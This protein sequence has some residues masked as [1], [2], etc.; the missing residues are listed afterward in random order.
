MRLG[1]SWPWERVRRPGV[2]RGKEGQS[3]IYEG[4]TRAIGRIASIVNIS[5]PAFSNCFTLFS[6]R[7]CSNQIVCIPLLKIGV[8][9]RSGNQWMLLHCGE[10]SISIRVRMGKRLRVGG[11]GSV[12]QSLFRSIW[13]RASAARTPLLAMSLTYWVPVSSFGLTPSRLP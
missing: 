9:S 3:K 13:A 6:V 5:L 11:T 8:H 1:Y 7:S 2:R 4:F 10:I 12:S